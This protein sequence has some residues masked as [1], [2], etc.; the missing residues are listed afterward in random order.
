MGSD[1]CLAAAS[2]G[3]LY[4]IISP[5]SQPLVISDVFAISESIL[6]SS[7]CHGNMVVTSDECGIVYLV[8]PC[9]K[10]ILDYWKGH[11]FEAW[12]V[13]LNR[14]DANLIL[15]GGDDCMARVWDRRL[16]FAKPVISKRHEM[17]VCSI[18]SVPGYCHFISTGCFDEKLRMW[19]LRGGGEILICH[20]SGGG[21]WRHKWSPSATKVLM[22]SMHA[23]FAVASIDGQENIIENTTGFDTSLTYYR[24]SAKLAYGVDWR[25]D[26]DVAKVVT[27]EP[28]QWGALCKLNASDFEPESVGQKDQLVS[29]FLKLGN[30][31]TWY[32]PPNKPCCFPQTWES[33]FIVHTR[34]IGRRPRSDRCLYRIRRNQTSPPTIE[35]IMIIGQTVLSNI[36]CDEW[37]GRRFDVCPK[38]EKECLHLPYLGEPRCISEAN[39]FHHIPS[40]EMSQ[41]ELWFTDARIPTG[42]VRR[43]VYTFTRKYDICRLER[44]QILTG[45]YVDSKSNCR[46]MFLMDQLFIPSPGSFSAEFRH[47]IFDDIFRC[48]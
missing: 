47:S 3:E 15:S 31:A 7:D 34:R 44:Y 20:T 43:H 35:S 48:P 24:Q 42:G 2:S 21:V 26:A 5:K 39:G 12:C 30:L 28:N 9:K 18:S 40:P 8:D 46:M 13:R 1:F 19:D 16:G 25:I 45:Q 22:A 14:N 29:M 37:K 11:D 32:A 10:K 23:G 6:L 36:L 41:K 17:G 4:T 27:T 38:D 33:E